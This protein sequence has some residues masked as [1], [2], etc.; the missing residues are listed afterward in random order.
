M[1]RP[2]S[3]YEKIQAG[4]TPLAKYQGHGTRPG[5]DRIRTDT[6]CHENRRR[7]ASKEKFSVQQHRIGMP[8]GIR[9]TDVFFKHARS[10]SAAV[11]TPEKYAK[12][13]GR[14]IDA[15]VDGHKYVSGKRAVVYGEEDLVVGMSSFLT[16]IGIQPVLCATGGSSGQIEGGHCQPPPVTPWPSS[17]RSLRTW[18]STRSTRWP[19]S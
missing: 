9:E 14:L 4:G 11:P 13:R 16:E 2:C 12:Q 19:N 15:Y 1:A 5:H 18:I 8:I 17:P 3:E 7:C 10:N 6:R